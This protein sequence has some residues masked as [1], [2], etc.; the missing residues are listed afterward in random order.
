MNIQFSDVSTKMTIYVLE[1]HPLMTQ[2]ITSLI[3]IIDPT[4]G[5][6]EIP[7]FINLQEIVSANGQPEVFIIEP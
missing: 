6:F 3:R 4:K 7:K 2:A 1:S 5:I